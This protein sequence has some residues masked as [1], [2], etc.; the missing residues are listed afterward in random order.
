MS[1]P[2]S[3]SCQANLF[4]SDF[5]LSVEQ[6]ELG[7]GEPLVRNQFKSGSVYLS[8]PLHIPGLQLLIDGIVDPEID[9]SPPVVLLLRRRHIGHS[10][11]VCFSDGFH[12]AFTLRQ[13]NEV[14]P[15]I[16]VHGVLL[17]LLLI[18]ELPL[19]DDDILNACTLT[20]LLLVD[21]IRLV[22]VR[23]LLLIHVVECILV[24]HPRPI[25]LLLV[26]LKLGKC[27]KQLLVH[28]LFPKELDGSLIDG[29]GTVQ[30]LVSQLKLYVSEPGL[31]VR[32][33][34]HPALKHCPGARDVVQHLLHVCVLVPE[35]GG[36]G[37]DGDSSVPQ[38]PC[39]VHLFVP[40]L[41][42]CVLQPQPYVTMINIKGTLV[43]RTTTVKLPL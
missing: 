32:L 12:I 21:R 18:L 1:A 37:Q 8:G 30:L 41:T 15:S 20:K 25:M 42:F 5:K 35:L 4:L 19:A 17:H 14:E 40:H 39:V 33:P 2:Q 31:L 10:T 26:L 29:P 43:H 11:L 38:V 3:S 13:A 22:Q 6:P 7:K 28:V 34:L 9:V 23:T 24:D 36:A 16:K 27:D